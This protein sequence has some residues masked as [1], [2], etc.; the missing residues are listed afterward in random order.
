MPNSSKN[1]SLLTLPAPRLSWVSVFEGVLSPKEK[2]WTD[3]LM[4]CHVP[5]LKSKSLN[6][7]SK[8]MASRS[9][10]MITP[11]PLTTLSQ[12]RRAMMISTKWLWSPWFPYWQTKVLSPVSHMGRLDPAKLTQWMVFTVLWS[13][14]SSI[15]WLKEWR[16]AWVSS[17]YMEAAA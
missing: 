2:R 1:C 13:T 11:L 3:K 15:L 17:N 10:W 8:S 4:Q 9:M 7:K 14:S 16:W 5:I 12:N 6:Q